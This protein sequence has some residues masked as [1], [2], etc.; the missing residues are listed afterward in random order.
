MVTRRDLLKTSATGALVGASV[1]ASSTSGSAATV[2]A[3]FGDGVNILPSYSCNGDQNLGW[4]LMNKHDKIQTV[5]IEM[6][7]PQKNRGDNLEMADLKRWIDEANW[8]GKDVIATFHHKP[9]IGSDS[10]SDLMEAAQWWADNYWYLSQ[11]T[12]FRI[13]LCNE[14]GDHNLGRWTYQDAY[15]DAITKIRNNTSYS[16][17]IVIDCPGWGQNTHVA[18]DAAGDL[19]DDNLILSS[20]IYP[21]AY[22]GD[23][24]RNVQPS[25]MDYLSNNDGGYPCMLGEFGDE[26]CCDKGDT[27]WSAI[28]DRANELDFPVF[29]WVWNGYEDPQYDENGDPCEDG[30]LMAWP[31]WGNSSQNGCSRDTFYERDSHFN[32]IYSK[33]GGGNE[34]QYLNAEYYELG[35][36]YTSTSRSG[37]WGDSY[38]T[39][40]DESGDYVKVWFDSATSGNRRVKIRYASPYD[41]K[42]CYLNVNGDTVAEPDLWYSTDFTTVD[43]GKH[44]FDAGNNEITIWKHYGY[45]D[46]D[47]IIVEA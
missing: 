31:A 28:V 42:K 37:Y 38:V 21:T 1:L 18:A 41:D 26:S 47:A 13:N 32:T 2:D 44:Y 12:D 11:D 40:F 45:Y 9:Y 3:P 4:D 25:D 30:C 7:P 19:T 36:T 15:N 14:W 46:I 29:G 39:G 33:L 22:N 6:E 34:T 27:D 10:K 24:N 35:G 43:T 20:H 17:D 5:R 23:Q 16:G 8:N